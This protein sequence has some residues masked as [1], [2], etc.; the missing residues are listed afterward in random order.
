MQMNEGHLRSSV[1]YGLFTESCLEGVE[2]NG[3]LLSS[4]AL[5]MIRCLLLKK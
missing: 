1:A 4:L 2:S 3:E 5:P